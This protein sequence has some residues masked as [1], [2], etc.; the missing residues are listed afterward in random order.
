MKA[1]AYAV[2]TM[3]L[4]SACGERGASSETGEKPAADAA[5]VRAEMEAKHEATS[6]AIDEARRT[7]TEEAA[8]EGAPRRMADVK[9]QLLPLIA[10]SY[11][12]ECTTKTGAASR[13]GILVSADG[14]VTAPGMK[15]RSLADAG[16]MLTFTRESAAS[17]APGIGFVGGD[18]KE[19]WSVS[20]SGRHE[21]STIFSDGGDAI[22]CVANEGP[23]QRRDGALYPVVARAMI[24]GAGTMQCTEGRRGRPGSYRLTLTQSE[25]SV[26]GENYSLT[27]DNAGEMVIADPRESTLTYQRGVNDGERIVI[28]LDRTG[29][30]GQFAATGYRGKKN[31]ECS[32]E[33]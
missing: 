26:G 31:F 12:G 29:R 17:N 2:C 30:I 1:I 32:A 5:Q 20:A 24:A 8:A 33:R 23:S 10:G 4:L 3:V 11:A 9:R 28:T 15:S 14:R 19:G 7:R 18:E 22:K 13:A 21:V 16:T 25:A 27:D 6:A